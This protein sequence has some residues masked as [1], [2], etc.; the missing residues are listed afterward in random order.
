MSE[1]GGSPS[2]RWAVGCGAEHRRRLLWRQFPSGE[3]T[4]LSGVACTRLPDGT[5]VAVLCCERDGWW[6]V[7]DLATGLSRGRHFGRP[8]PDTAPWSWPSSTVAC[9]RLRDGAPVAVTA[10]GDGVLRVWD[11]LTGRLRSGSPAGGGR[12]VY[13]LDG[14]QEVHHALACA[15]LADGA[16]VAV[17]GSADGTI[18]F[19]D[20]ETGQPHDRT[21]RCEN[22]LPRVACTGLTDG[23]PVAVIGDGESLRVWDL[24][25]GRFRGEPVVTDFTVS[26]LA[27]LRL[28]DG[29]P[30]AIVRGGRHGE[31]ETA[32]RDGTVQAWDLASGRRYGRPATDHGDEFGGLAATLL[33]DGTPI[34]VSLGRD[35]VQAWNLATGQPH[36][37]SLPHIGP[38]PQLAC[39][40]LPDGTP[41]LVVASEDMQVWSLRVAP[42]AQGLTGPIRIVGC[43]GMPGGGEVV[44]T[45][46]QEDR[47][48]PTVQLWDAGTGRLRDR[49]LPGH[50]DDAA[51][52]ARLPDGAAVVVTPGKAIPGDVSVRLWDLASGDSSDV[53]LAGH[54]GELDVLDC[55]T[56]ADGA[57]IL[58]TG[59]PIRAW[60]LDTGRPY[61]PP[62]PADPDSTRAVASLPLIDGT[63][64]AIVLD[65]ES[66]RAWDLRTGRP[67]GPWS[68]RPLR[69]DWYG[70]AAGA[71]LADGTPV[72]VAVDGNDYFGTPGTL[73]AWD[74]TTGHP[75]GQ[76]LPLRTSVPHA[77]A[78]TRLPDGTVLAAVG[79]DGKLQEDGLVEICD[80]AGGH[81]LPAIDVPEPVL[82][83]AFT[84]EHRLV[85]RTR[86][87]VTVY[88]VPAI[89]R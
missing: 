21:V 27:C 10:D 4:M 14:G 30:L 85:V 6:E 48:G 3:A 81:T 62:L 19:W 55:V 15:R 54:T 74:L 70:V 86:F 69:D 11:L 52:C 51:A 56:L 2:V 49:L 73:R 60:E 59:G 24:P 5:V 68:V 80:P 84:A 34:A 71:L 31:E 25:A 65:D 41:V 26:H 37:T 53:V 17:T 29:T 76:P 45:V 47:R 72:A 43:V 38:P 64:L 12:E 77:V 44:V 36:G 20:V 88:D 83:L 57:P 42:S 46:A 28:S 32:W 22:P 89:R 58:V 39:T 33:A 87:D 75:Y 18:R 40:E 82:G 35:G 16:A 13:P 50:G 79:G 8:V 23:T 1:H 9:T 63:L 67:H 66:G 7:V 61:G 78:C